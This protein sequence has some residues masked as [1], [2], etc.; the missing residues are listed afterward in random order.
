MNDLWH[1]RQVSGQPHGES[2]AGN[3]NPHY[4]HCCWDK[5]AMGIPTTYTAAGTSRQ[6]ESPQWESPL[7]TLLLGQGQWESPLHTLLLGQAGNGNPHNGN[8]HYIHCCW[9]KGN[10]NPHY[11]HCCWDKGNGNP[12]YIHCCW[13]KLAMG[14]PTTYTAA[15]TRAMGIPTT[16]TAAGTSGQWESPLHTVLL[17][18]HHY[19]KPIT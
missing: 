10:G 16:Y 2:Q 5:L 12:H 8:P 6:W 9:D 13:D 7:H 4:I 17:G 14:I 18:L 19:I 1:P 15:G 11:I 3:G